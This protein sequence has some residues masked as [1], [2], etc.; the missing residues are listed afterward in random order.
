MDMIGVK[1]GGP[2]HSTLIRI[3]PDIAAVVGSGFVKTSRERS[4]LGRNICVRNDTDLNWYMVYD[5]YLVTLIHKVTK[6]RRSLWC[7]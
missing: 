1:H 3:F 2:Y 6:Y 4:V 5:D 7:G